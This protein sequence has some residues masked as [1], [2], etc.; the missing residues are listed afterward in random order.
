V[1]ESDARSA[2][3]RGEVQVTELSAAQ[4]AL[5]RGVAES[6]AT[7]PHVY[8]EASVDAAP[9][10]PALLRAAAAALRAVPLLNGAYRDGRFEA[11][12]RIN[13]A[14]AISAGGTLALP[15]IHDADELDEEGI[16]DRLAELASGARSG[17]LPSPAFAGATFTVIDMS[18]KAERFTPVVNHGQA[19]TLG[20]GSKALVLAC[21]ARIVQGS[22]GADLLA[23]IKG[24]GPFTTER[25]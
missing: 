8:F 3:A 22:E 7:V 24:S 13:L 16:A 11:Y 12:G 9:S 6:K 19:G 5:A 10:L 15:V 21:D 25:S 20:C 17:S 1:S 23:H 4:R 14:V 2:G 18:A